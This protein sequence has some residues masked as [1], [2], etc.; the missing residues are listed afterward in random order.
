M[1]KFFILFLFTASLSFA[2]EASYKVLEFNK[3]KN[4]TNGEIISIDL[5]I[6]YKKDNV[7]RVTYSHFSDD[8]VKSYVKNESY[9]QVLV[10][11]MSTDLKRLVEGA[12]PIA[13]P[14]VEKASKATLD[15]IVIDPAKIK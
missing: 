9:L 2:G 11:K 6:E 5:T 7:T 14:V 13:T 4:P 12:P 15:A 1:K 10:E 3:Y 8:E